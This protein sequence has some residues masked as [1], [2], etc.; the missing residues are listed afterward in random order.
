[1]KKSIFGLAE[2]LVGLIAYFGFFF[3]GIAVLIL[4]KENKTVRFHA[5]QSTIWFLFLAVI[6]WV[7]LFFSGFPLLGFVFTLIRLAVKVITVLSWLFLMYS[8]F[9][10]KEFKIP[11]IGDVVHA[12]IY[13]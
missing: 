4:E 8:A 7:A 10:G 1:M 12:Q 3:T 5:L 11:I 2:N 9:S 13:R 6:G